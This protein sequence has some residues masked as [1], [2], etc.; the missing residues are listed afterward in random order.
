MDHKL[1]LAE[2]GGGIPDKQSHFNFMIIT[3]INIYHGLKTKNKKSLQMPADKFL[4]KPHIL[5]KIK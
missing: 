5:I 3:Q 4:L 2:H 1:Y